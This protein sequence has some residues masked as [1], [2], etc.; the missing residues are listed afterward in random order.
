[1]FGGETNVSVGQFDQSSIE[2]LFG[3]CHG[4]VSVGAEPFKALGCLF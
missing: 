4:R 3:V 1:M 2:I